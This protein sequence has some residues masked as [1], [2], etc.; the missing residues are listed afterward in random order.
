LQRAQAIFDE[1]KPAAEFIVAGGRATTVRARGVRLGV[2]VGDAHRPLLPL[3]DEGCAALK[4][5]L[6]DARPR[7]R[8]R[9]RFRPLL[10]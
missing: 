4:K 7:H 5:L 8:A 1:L 2:D 10:A 6:T 9:H 3:D